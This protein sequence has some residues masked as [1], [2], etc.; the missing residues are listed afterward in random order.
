MNTALA[1]GPN[2]AQILM[3]KLRVTNQVFP[4]LYLPMALGLLLEHVIMTVMVMMPVTLGYMN[5][6]LAAGR[7]WA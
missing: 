7:N 5:T 4:Y 2:W 3:A 6:A 1:A